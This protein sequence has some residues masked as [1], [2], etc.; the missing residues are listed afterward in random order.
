MN[1][2]T[3][4]TDTKLT[5]RT[6]TN[7]IERKHTFLKTLPEFITNQT[8][9]YKPYFVTFTFQNSMSI[10]PYICYQDYFRFFYRQLCQMILNRNSNYKKP[11]LLLVPETS[12]QCVD[13]H[14]YPSPHFHGYLLIHNQTVQKFENKCIAYKYRISNQ[15][16]LQ[17]N[18]IDAYPK[19][20]QND[21]K[22]RA[23]LTDSVDVRELTSSNNE[24]ARTAFYSSK[25][26]IKSPFHYDD[27]IIYSRTYK[28]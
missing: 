9:M 15:V 26:F 27:L 3:S 5:Y 24:L 17:S 1:I 28:A 21:A 18:L 8:P 11:T 4:T 23:I 12:Y 16:M 2:K 10:L 22:K 13:R 20:I 19:A 7:D 25:N 14:M 6:A